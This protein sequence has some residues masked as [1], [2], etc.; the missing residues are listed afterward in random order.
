M[1]PVEWLAKGTRA[2]A[3]VLEVREAGWEA[4]VVEGGEVE[5]V[6]VVVVVMVARVEKARAEEV[7]PMAMAVALE[8]VEPMAMA[9]TLARGILAMAVVE[10][11]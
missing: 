4:R 1:A 8:K 5:M 6:R 3:R 7:E 2:W 9:V 11:A 10:V